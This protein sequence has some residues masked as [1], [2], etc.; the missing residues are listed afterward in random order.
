MNPSRRFGIAWQFIQDESPAANFALFTADKIGFFSIAEAD[1]T[2]FR[3]N[4]ANRLIL[5]DFVFVDTG[6]VLAVDD[7]KAVCIIVPIRK[8]NGARMG[9]EN[10]RCSQSGK[11]WFVFHIKALIFADGQL[12][13][14]MWPGCSKD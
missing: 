11:N 8:C 4:F 3:T 9:N 12:V 7:L 2:A 14:T 5:A 13:I 1:H 6:R 10:H